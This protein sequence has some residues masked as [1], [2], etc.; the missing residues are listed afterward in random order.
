MI[1]G[2][3]AAAWRLPEIISD[4]IEM[5]EAYK[6]IMKYL[7]ATQVSPFEV[8]FV[9]NRDPLATSVS[10]DTLEI[11]EPSLLIQFEN[12]PIDRMDEVIPKMEKLL[13]QIV[14]DGP[15]KFDL[16][17]LKFGADQIQFI[18]DT[19]WVHIRYTSSTHPVEIRFRL[20]TD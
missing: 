19:H 16:G 13:I 8:A 7:T 6:L 3:I 1:S 2:N 11:K 14:K 15:E 20:G 10:S 17:R 12:V 18:S 9:E 5:L 4:N